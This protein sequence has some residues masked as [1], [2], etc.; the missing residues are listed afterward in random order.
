MDVHPGAVPVT[1]VRVVS[2]AGGPGIGPHLLK[3]AQ[4][5]VGCA[6]NQEERHIEMLELNSD[7]AQ[8]PAN[9][10]FGLYAFKPRYA[11]PRLPSGSMNIGVCPVVATLQL[12][13]PEAPNVIVNLES[14]GGVEVKGWLETLVPDR[15]YM[16]VN[17]RGN[18]VV[19]E[20]NVRNDE[21]VFFA[22]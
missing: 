20:C 22:R 5:W 9:E 19:F 7:T 16:V 14:E 3:R 10:G 18:R 11:S 13:Q 15:E 6:T 1:N 4:T 2:E 8:S 12:R 17:P 21:L